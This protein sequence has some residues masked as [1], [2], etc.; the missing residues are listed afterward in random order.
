MN[1]PAPAPDG[2][3]EPMTLGA[4]ITIGG[5]PLSIVIVWWI[6]TFWHVTLSPVE[7]SAIGAVGA[8][9][10]GG[11]IHYGGAIVTALLKKAG[12][13]PPAA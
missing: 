13:K 2:A 1:A 12:I 6:T 4:K 5:A 9:A 8:S 7:A 10:I 11:I 3:I